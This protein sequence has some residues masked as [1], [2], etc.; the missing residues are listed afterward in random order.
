[1]AHLLGE[2]AGAREEV[3]AVDVNLTGADLD[4]VL[5]GRELYRQDGYCGTCHGPDG[6]GLKAAGFPPLAGTRWVNEDKER[7]IKLTLHGMMGPIE[8]LGEE[9]PRSEEHTSELQSRGHLVCRL[10]LEKKKEL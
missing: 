9:Y 1:M 2:A 10:L 5:R 3:E 4:Q 8:V 6:Q 7:L